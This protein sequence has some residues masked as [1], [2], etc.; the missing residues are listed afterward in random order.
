MDTQQL[1]TKIVELKKENVQIENELKNAQATLIEM[2]QVMEQ[3]MK[4]YEKKLFENENNRDNVLDA[5]IN[6]AR[7]NFFQDFNNKNYNYR[8]Q[9]DDLNTLVKGMQKHYDKEITSIN[10]ELI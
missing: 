1:K 4:G 5:K 2:K 9:I 6:Q 10:H 3:K 7:F 8:K